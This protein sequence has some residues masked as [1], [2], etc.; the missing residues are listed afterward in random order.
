MKLRTVP[1]ACSRLSR[2]SEG[3]TPSQWR[4]WQR[5][6]RGQGPEGPFG[7]MST[8]K[9]FAHQLAAQ[10]GLLCEITSQPERE[11]AP[12]NLNLPLIVTADY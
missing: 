5:R 4:Y 1:L 3:A 10:W 8:F 2:D 9:L 12:R 7:R 6:P 11:F